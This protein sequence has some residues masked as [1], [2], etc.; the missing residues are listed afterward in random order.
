MGGSSTCSKQNI[1]V[2]KLKIGMKAEKALQTIP[3]FEKPSFDIIRAWFVTPGFSM[4]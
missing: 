3:E 2:N 1:R 4:R